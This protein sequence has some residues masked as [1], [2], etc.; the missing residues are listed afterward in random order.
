VWVE[1][2]ELDRVFH[3]LDA[4]FGDQLP[5]IT[6]AELNLIW[7]PDTNFMQVFARLSA[8]EQVDQDALVDAIEP[9]VGASADQSAR[10]VA[11]RLAQALVVLLPEAKGG[12][13]RV[14]YE[15]RQFENRLEAHME[16]HHAETTEQLERIEGAVS[17]Q[18][19]PLLILSSDWPSAAEDALKRATAEDEPGLRKLTQ[20]LAG[21]TN[22][23]ELP[24]LINK[25][26]PWMDDLSAAVWELLAVLSQEEGLWSEAQR[27]WLTARDKP[28]ADWPGCT[29][30]AAESAVQAG[31]R[32]T[33]VALLDAAREDD[34]QHPR[35][36]FHDALRQDDPKD[37]LAALERIETTDRALAAAVQVAKVSVHVELNDFAAARAALGVAANAG[38]RETLSYR[39]AETTLSMREMLAAERPSATA[40]ASFADG[41]LQLERELLK[42][43]QL[44]QAAG[45]RAQAAA[46]YGFIGDIAQAQ[47][48]LSA[49]VDTYNVEQRNRACSWRWPRRTST[50]TTRSRRSSTPTTTESKRA[51]C[52]LR[53]GHAETTKTSAPPPTSLMSSS[54]T[55]TRMCASWQRCAGWPSAAR[56][57]ASSGA[58]K[59]RLSSR[60]A[61]PSPL[62]SS[63]PSGWRTRA[64]TRRQSASCW[65]TPTR[66]GRS[67][68]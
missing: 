36:L 58:T 52:E 53:S 17:R 4:A 15:M 24:T 35:V 61:M 68:S 30:R 60:A 31:D 47:A 46:F 27:A 62:S 57:T 13:E 14:L 38:A 10:D 37:A 40:A 21:K 7:R 29:V 20:A 18:S 33:A 44:A 39:M 59:P 50:A 2:D 65:R 16:S 48:L 54:A 63:R 8:G 22:A 3:L 49:A 6:R 43:N 41:A 56:R 1:A 45:V 12:T 42:R 25:G 66:R 34:D 55:R 9:L 51:T 5:A 64:A 19:S 23:H 32:A 67:P 26:R 28:G 11:G